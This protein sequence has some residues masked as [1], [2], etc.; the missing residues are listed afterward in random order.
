M[1][2]ATSAIYLTDLAKKH[3]N[4]VTS[5]KDGETT[6]SGDKNDAV[7]CHISENSKLEYK[8]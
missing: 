4:K 2:I 5:T 7:D 3:R 8:E 1:K 6:V